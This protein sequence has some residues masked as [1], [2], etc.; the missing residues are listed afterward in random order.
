MLEYS[1]ITL[2]IL[3]DQGKCLYEYVV[4]FEFGISAKQLL[5]R[6]FVAAQSTV[7]A[8]PFLFTLE[9]FGY[10]ESA[11]FPGYLGYEVES[12]KNLQTD[13]QHFWDLM[14]DGV[15]TLTGVDTT[16]PQPGGTVVLQY[17]QIPAQP[18]NPRAA[19][20]QSRKT[21]QK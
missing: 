15:S 21:R 6:A 9:Y 1:P 4:P 10:S 14:L 20:V 8:D 18:T 17:T 2:Q 16:F 5:E 19:A 13:A 3:D 7:D 12:I 11:E